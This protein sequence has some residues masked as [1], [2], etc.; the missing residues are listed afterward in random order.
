M[1]A[2]VTASHFVACFSD[3]YAN[4]ILYLIPAY[5]VFRVLKWLANYI[6]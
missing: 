2:V 6:K 1:F 4:Y 3:T 5:L